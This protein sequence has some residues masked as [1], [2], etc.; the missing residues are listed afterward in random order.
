MKF[1]MRFAIPLACLSLGALISVGLFWKK[2]TPVADDEMPVY[3]NVTDSQGQPAPEVEG[4][5]KRWETDTDG[6]IVR[7]SEKTVRLQKSGTDGRLLIPVRKHPDTS[8]AA[9]HTDN[10]RY[11]LFLF[12]DDEAT[13]LIWEPNQVIHPVV[14]LEPTVEVTLK[15]EGETVP[16]QPVLTLRDYLFPALYPKAAGGHYHNPK[17]QTDDTWTVNLVPGETYVIGWPAG[18]DVM[19]GYLSPEFTAEEGLVVPFSPGLPASVEYVIPAAPEGLRMFPAKVYLLK[20]YEN[21]LSLNWRSGIPVEK[22]GVIHFE[23]LAKGQFELRAMIDGSPPPMEPFFNDVRQ[24][25]LKSGETKMIAAEMPHIDREIE[26]GDIIVRGVILDREGQPVS[27]ESIYLFPQDVDEPEAGYFKS[28]QGIE[29]GD[30]HLGDAMSYYPVQVSNERG[31]FEFLGVDPRQSYVVLTSD[32]QG[33]FTHPSLPANSIPTDGVID[34]IL[35]ERTEEVQ[36]AVGSPMPDLLLYP[37]DGTELK[38]SEFEGKVVVIDL[39]AIWCAACRIELPMIADLS[40]QYSRDD[41]VFMAVSLDAVPEHW[42]KL[43]QKDESLDGL[44]HVW[45]D[46]SK[47]PPLA[48][49]SIPYKVILNRNGTIHAV[50]AHMDLAQMLQELGLQQDSNADSETA[51][52]AEETAG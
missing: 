37:E 52:K 31:E 44:L 26:P 25:I 8:Q 49:P 45:L 7:N 38:F 33:E 51:D 30:L 47:N 1:R 43:L 34:L 22:A 39:W 29:I 11:E 12:N 3:L 5:L 14:A 18:E 40:R 23:N 46:P 20:K 15:L 16:A 4:I 19:F 41:L 17:R 2:E 35:C 48:N 36:L 32:P 50:G 42:T 13:R 27:G 6:K 9:I 24:V 10:R 28:N 21:D